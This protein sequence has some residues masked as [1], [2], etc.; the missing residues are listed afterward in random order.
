MR[1]TICSLFPNF[2]DSPLT[3]GLMARARKSG[4]LKVELV[5]PRDFTAGR[6]HR[7]DDRPYGGGPGMVMLLD[8]LVRALESLSE[9]GHILTLTPRGRPFIQAD[10]VRLV[11]SSAI[12]VVCGRYEGVDER[13]GELFPVEPVSVGDFVLNGG[14]AAA[15]CVLEAVARLLPNYMGHETA[16]EE[17]SFSAGLLEYPHYTRPA[18]YRGLVVPAVLQSGNHADVA[19]WRREASL[20][21]TWRERPELLA[22]AQLTSADF[23][24]LRRL[25]TE[26]ERV[27]LGRNLHVF[28]IHYQVQDDCEK[29]MPLFLTNLD[30]HDIITFIDIYEL[31]GYW[32]VMPIENQ[33]QFAQRLLDN[34]TASLA[35]IRNHDYTVPLSRLH[36]AP[37]IGVAMAGVVEAAGERPLVVATGAS[38]GRKDWRGTMLTPT[39]LRCELER[40]PVALFLGMGSGLARSVLAGADEFLAPVRG[41]RTYNHLSVRSAAAIIIDRIL[42]DIF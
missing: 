5:N 27:R 19:T 42:G 17:E 1:F 16:A 12:T 4:L 9:P 41:L 18:R 38:V 31:G 35:G 14:E 8:P 2:F 33:Q 20:I 28:L 15:L 11:H 21:S 36:V 26:S 10:A 22:A 32:L 25:E 34:W 7:V 3:C 23:E 39:G 6:H 29:N 13:L 30:V 37:D 24:T 40:R